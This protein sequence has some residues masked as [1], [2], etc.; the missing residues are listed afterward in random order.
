MEWVGCPAE[1]IEARPFIH[2][3]AQRIRKE[4][5][6]E[7]EVSEETWLSV[8]LKMV[9][10]LRVERFSGFPAELIEERHFIHT[11]AQRIRKEERHEEE[12]S[13]ETWLS[14]FLK[15]VFVSSCGKI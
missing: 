12:V 2:A 15:K 4:E 5:R 3:K 13:E 6:H 7:E 14:V 10:C 1:L 9:S 11:K 8:F